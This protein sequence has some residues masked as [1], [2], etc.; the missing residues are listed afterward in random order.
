MIL[1]FI[2]NIKGFPLFKG[3]FYPLLLL[4]NDLTVSHT[5]GFSNIPK[6][7]KKIEEHQFLQ[8]DVEGM[9]SPAATVGGLEESRSGEQQRGTII[10]LI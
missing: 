3:H 4:T 6:Q 2:L 1:I 9:L 7:L 8:S 5:V 10:Y